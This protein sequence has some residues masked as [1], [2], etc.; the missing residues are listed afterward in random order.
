MNRWFARA[1]TFLTSVVLFGGCAAGPKSPP[2][3]DVLQHCP[4]DSVDRRLAALRKDDT[5]VLQLAGGRAVQL[6][7]RDA[8]PDV[9]AGQGWEL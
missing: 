7:L 1:M 4:S 2:P 8:G 5:V 6:K 9:Y 3:A